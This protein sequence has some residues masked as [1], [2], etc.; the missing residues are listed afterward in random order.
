MVRS[1]NECAEAAV[2]IGWPVA[3]K[4]SGSAIQHKSELD[5]LAL[6]IADVPTLLAECRRLLELPGG[7]ESEL[8]VESMAPPGV[9][10][11]VAARADAVVPALVVGLGGI[12][13]EALDDVAVIPLPASPGPGRAG[14]ALAAR[15]RP[16]R[17]RHAAAPASTSRPWRSP[18]PEPVSSCST[19]GSS[20]SSSTR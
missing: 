8:L 18:P 7:H 11:L 9:E 14:A 16:P 20:C 12:W 13:T 4:L 19:R 17:R 5:A 1:P 15:R 3:L 2:E 6:G 10:L